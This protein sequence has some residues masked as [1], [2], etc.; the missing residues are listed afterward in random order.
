MSKIKKEKKEL[1][2]QQIKVRNILGWVV[3][4]LCIALIITSLVISIVTIA[5]AGNTTGEL[6][7]IGGNVFMPVQTDSMEPTFKAGDLI[8]TKI[9]EGD[10]SDLKVGQV[11]T[12]RDRVGQNGV[13]YE[14]FVTHRIA[15]IGVDENGKVI[16]FKVVGDNPNPQDGASGTD[17]VK[18]S[19][20]VATWGT[21]AEQ[22]AD[23]TFNVTKDTKGGNMGQIGALINFI[24]HDKTNY[25]LII[26]LPL[27]IIFLI[28]VFFLVRSLV[29][30]KIAKTKEEAV[31]TAVDGLSEEDKRR[32]AE[33]YLAQLAREQ[34]QDKEEEKAEEPVF[35]EIDEKGDEQA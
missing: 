22:N 35:E 15:D 21:P 9:Y 33:E 23:G 30:A 13:T 2:P 26:V 12:Y 34:A 4:A 28:Y 7:G 3:T 32:L 24:Q 29:I 11:I 6:K 25:F 19:D 31:S 18:V 16:Q 10:G 1:T 17:T 5:N 8:I 20:V 27:I 14:I